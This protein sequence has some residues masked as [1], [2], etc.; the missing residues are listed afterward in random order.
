MEL[1]STDYLYYFSTPIKLSLRDKNIL[2]T[3]WINFITELHL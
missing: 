1:I 3:N 2:K